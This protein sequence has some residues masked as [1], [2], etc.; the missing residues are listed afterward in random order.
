[1][2]GFESE[3]S[4]EDY[5]D[6]QA[7]IMMIRNNYTTVG[8]RHC[9]L[10]VWY[11]RD[12][13]MK[14]IIDPI[15][16][17]SEENISDTLTKNT[18]RELFEKHSLKMVEKVPPEYLTQKMEEAELEH[19]WSLKRSPSISAGNRSLGGCLKDVFCGKWKMVKKWSFL[20]EKSAKEKISSFLCRIKYISTIVSRNMGTR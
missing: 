17:K 20:S 18:T 13:N 12:L 14:G 16:V 10:R 3:T 1:M 8:S 7:A 5:L 19:G 11:L 9:S 4:N 6:N 15:Y 2:D